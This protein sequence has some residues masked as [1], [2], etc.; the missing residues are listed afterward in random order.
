M[1]KEQ[2]NN[3]EVLHE[4][5]MMERGKFTAN[6]HT[7]M[8]RPVYLKEESEYFSEMHISPAPP[9]GEEKTD[10]ELAQY[11]IALFGD[12]VNNPDGGKKESGLKGFFSRLFRRRNYRYYDDVPVIQPLV[13]WLERKVTY[14]GRRIRFYDLER[15]YGLNKAEIEKLII[16]FQQISFFQ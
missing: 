9:S 5:V 15:K 6:G 1:S 3:L 16:Y 7:F 8:V 4:D 10:K 12:H 2:E 14:K 13:K 11:A